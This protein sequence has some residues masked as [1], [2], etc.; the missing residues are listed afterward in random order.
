MLGRAGALRAG[1]GLIVVG[2]FG[3]GFRLGFGLVFRRGASGCA[4]LA[5]A[6]VCGQ[7]GLGSPSGGDAAGVKPS[8]ALFMASGDSAA[9]KV[10]SA[11]S[12]AR[13]TSRPWIAV[14][15]RLAFSC[16]QLS[17]ARRS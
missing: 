11:T 10:C 12:V 14:R 8:N 9:P 5:V 17:T 3:L 2:V 15:S 6:A 7:A 1:F 13:C 4:G 16:S